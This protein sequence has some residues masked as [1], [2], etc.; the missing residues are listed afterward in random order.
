MPDTVAAHKPLAVRSIIA[1]K[2]ATAAIPGLVNSPHFPYRGALPNSSGPQ[3]AGYAPGNLNC[4]GK[5][6]SHRVRSKHQT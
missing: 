4:L 3:S 1:G 2:P 6:T 5:R